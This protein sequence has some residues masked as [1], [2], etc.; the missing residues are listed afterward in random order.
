[1]PALPGIP[2]FDEISRR[3]LALVERRLTYYVELYSSGRWQRYY[4]RERFILL[5]HDAIHVVKTARRLTAPPPPPGSDKTD[6][7]PAA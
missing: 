3:W 2:H 7:R 5:M 1:M 4:T 6:L